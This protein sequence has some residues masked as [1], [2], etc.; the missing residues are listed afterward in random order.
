MRVLERRCLD[1]DKHSH[2]AVIGKS[3][4]G[5]SH[6][7]EAAAY[8][9]QMASAYASA[10]RTVW[11]RGISP[12]PLSLW[13]LPFEDFR[14]NIAL[15]LSGWKGKHNAAAPPGDLAAFCGRRKF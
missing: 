2:R 15:E 1:T 7:S 11:L 4:F 3:D 13:P 8:P 6:A 5:E 9:K 10:V 12:V 14:A